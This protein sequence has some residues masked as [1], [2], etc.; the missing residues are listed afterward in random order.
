MFIPAGVGLA[1]GMIGAGGRPTWWRCSRRPEA[2][3][4]RGCRR[5][6]SSGARSVGERGGVT[7][8]VELAKR[9][10]AEP[11]A[12]GPAPGR[13]T[14][15]ANMTG[16]TIMGRSLLLAD[17]GGTHVRLR[18]LSPEGHIVNELQEVGSGVG[19]GTIRSLMEELSE[20]G[21]ASG[22]GAHRRPRGFACG[23]NLPGPV[24]GARRSE[25]PSGSWPRTSR[26]PA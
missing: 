4:P 21:Q 11:P 23:H 18:H 10:L 13:P 14:A 22:C 3:S 17:V 2:T 20:A 15:R 5:S 26:P 8:V 25:T 6:S 9:R 19:D 16:G 24:G 1:G 12:L 7:G